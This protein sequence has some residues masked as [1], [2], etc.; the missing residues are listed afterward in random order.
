MTGDTFRTMLATEMTMCKMVTRTGPRMKGR[1][2]AR[3]T[4]ARPNL[5]FSQ[6]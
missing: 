2:M 1:R 3:K 5:S 6:E 4:E